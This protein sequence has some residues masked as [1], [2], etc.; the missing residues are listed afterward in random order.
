MLEALETVSYRRFADWRNTPVPRITAGVYTIWD[1]QRFIYVGMSGRGMV[2]N[3]VVA[4]DEPTKAKGLWTRLNSHA[5]GRRS[6]DQFCVYVCDRFVV[7]AL[8][9]EQQTQIGEGVLSLDALTRKYI[10]NNL[11]YRYVTLDNGAAAFE[12]ERAVQRGALTVGKPLL[13]PL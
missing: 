2:T 8:T 7:P 9:S 6:G 3:D 12:L 10:H 11:A 13:N 1:K 4:T 5:S